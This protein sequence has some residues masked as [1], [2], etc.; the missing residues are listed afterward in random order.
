[1]HVVLVVLSLLL[2]FS[3]GAKTNQALTKSATSSAEAETCHLKVQTVHYPPLAIAPNSAF[4]TTNQWLGMN[5]TYLD[6]LFNEANCSYS[7]YATPLAR[8]LN[9]LE[10]G[11]V[12]MTLNLSKT[13]EREAYLAFVGVH[14]IEKIILAAHRDF[15][16]LI[17]DFND[18]S[19]H[20]GRWIW[21]KGA[22]YG[23]PL[24]NLAKSDPTFDMR[25]NRSVDN[26]RMLDFI[27][28]RRADGFFVEST[29][30]EF[31][32]QYDARYEMLERHPITINSEAVYFVFSKQSMKPELIEKFRVAY[33][34]LA[35]KGVWQQINSRTFTLPDNRS[36]A[37]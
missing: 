9:L 23:E 11:V 29:N 27:R 24:A 34:N 7:I 25:I 2:S 32:K 3:V 6:A 13:A 12:D 16:P 33:E 8:G 1:M 21:Q 22:Y 18:L 5:F 31:H 28:K 20:D 14:R 4:N 17:H 36:L 26:D 19:K 15:S 35:E 30:F 37:P 10:Q